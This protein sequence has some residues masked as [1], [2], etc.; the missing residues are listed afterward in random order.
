LRRGYRQQQ[1]TP[2]ER[3]KRKLCGSAAERRS[4]KGIA[5]DK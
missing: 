2:S 5:R 3:R 1:T 4:V